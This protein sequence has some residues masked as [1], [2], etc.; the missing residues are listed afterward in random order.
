MRAKLFIFITFILSIY[1]CNRKNQENMSKNDKVIFLHHSTG[2]NIWKG[3]VSKISWKLFKEGDAQKQIKKLNKKHK[4]NFI[5]SELWYPE[6]SDNNPVDYYN[7][8]IK[9]EQEAELPLESFTEKYGTVVFKHCF[10]ISSIEENDGMPNVAS[11]KH[12]LAN[13]KLQY[14]ALKKKLHEFPDTKFLIW[15]GATHVKAATNEAS[16]KR[17]KEFTDWV[18]NDWDEKGDNVFLW[19]FYE[20]ETEGGLYLKD[21]YAYSSTD[22]H[23]G[24]EFAA[25]ASV[26]FV[27]RLFD[28][29]LGKADENPLT[30]KE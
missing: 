25:K 3:N 4:T 7:I 17:M 10:P 30:G 9:K 5:L 23:P 11:E 24:K 27:N 1:S 16:A 19:D 12:T 18:R 29:L 28:V 26:F 14:E 22:S 6:N 2:F 21:A 8:W 20:L 15:T 13:Y